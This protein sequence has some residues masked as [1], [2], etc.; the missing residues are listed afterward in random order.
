MYQAMNVSLGLDGLGRWILY[1]GT[2]HRRTGCYTAA[3]HGLHTAA[4][5]LLQSQH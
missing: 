1:E 4:M 5:C 2:V 3:K